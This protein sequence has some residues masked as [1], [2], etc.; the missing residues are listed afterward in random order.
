[1]TYD[2][3]QLRIYKDGSFRDNTSV[4]ESI[5]TNTDNLL[6]GKY[7]TGTLDEL[8]VSDIARGAAWINTTYQNTNS[9]TTFA[10]FGSQIGILTTWSYRKQISINASMV[11]TDLPYFPVLISTT[12]ANLRDNAHSSG[13]DIIFLDA[14]TSWTGCWNL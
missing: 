11:D 2:G 7:L 6:L 1:M 10:T 3:S 9:P 4:G 8:R 12:D 5:S 14:T 13:N